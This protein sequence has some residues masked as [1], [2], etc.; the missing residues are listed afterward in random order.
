MIDI[1]VSLSS[2]YDARTSYYVTIN[3]TVYMEIKRETIHHLPVTIAIKHS[4]PE[5]AVP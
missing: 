4:L 5:S 2:Y 3:T 1:T